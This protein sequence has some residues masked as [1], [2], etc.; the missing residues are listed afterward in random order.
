[1]LK[2]VFQQDEVLIQ[3]VT[4]LEYFNVNNI[5]THRYIYISIIVN[6]EDIKM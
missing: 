1:M 2:N 5:H 4:C 6:L 3:Y